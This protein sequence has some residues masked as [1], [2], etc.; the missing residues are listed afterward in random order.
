MTQS[1]SALDAPL[2]GH[3][4]TLATFEP[5]GAPVVSLYLNLAPDQRGRDNYEAFCRKAFAGQLRAFKEHE[6]DH[7]SLTRD[8]ERITAYLADEVNR[9]ANGL[10]LFSS[11]GA[12]DF[13][14]AV[15]LD[16]PIDDHWLF[17]GPVPHLYPLVRLI[18]QY[19]RYA[20]VV[21]DTNQARIF[22]FGLGTI[23]RREEVKGVK[24]RRNSMGGWSQARYQR[25]AENFHLHHINEVVETLDRVVRADNV[26]HIIILGDDVVVPMLKAAMPAHLTEK[27]VDVG[28]VERHAREDEIVE[29]TLD[30]LRQKDADTDRESVAELVGAWQGGGLGVLG[31]EATLRAL[32]MGQVEELMSAATAAA[33]KP[34]QQLPDDAAPGPLAAETSAARAA[35]DRQLQLSDELVTRAQQTGARVRMIEDPELLRDHGGVGATLRFRI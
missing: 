9:A 1:P 15:Q 23:E 35:S 14:E 16:V 13:F 17:I 25:R 34:V 20:S 32:Q 21:L 24:T 33:L 4:R 5:Q 11:A 28:R 3:L 22:V 8:V 2:A 30:V 26:Q 18:D 6:A 29:A 31:P 19:P 10:A 27:L 12:G 7:A